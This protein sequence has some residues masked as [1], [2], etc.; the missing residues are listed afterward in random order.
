M[1]GKKGTMALEVEKFAHLLEAAFA[2]PVLL[3]DERLSSKGADAKLK[4]ISL[5]RKERS[6]KID[7]MAAIL[8][9]QTYLDR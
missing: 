5:N 8:L 3:V 9:L 4:E 2:I 1:S 7:M 6:A